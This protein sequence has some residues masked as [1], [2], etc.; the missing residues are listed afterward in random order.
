MELKN[1]PSLPVDRAF[2]LQLAG[3]IDL[4]GTEVSG[5]I[6]HVR[7]GEAVHFASM[8]ELLSFLRQVLSA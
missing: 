3:D 1:R 7:T 8:P 4:E 5:R 6:E 2:L